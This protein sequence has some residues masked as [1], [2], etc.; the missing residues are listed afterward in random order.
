ML[1]SLQDMLRFEEREEIFFDTAESFSSEESFVVGEDLMCHNFGYNFLLNELKSVK[2]R[3]ENFLVRMGLMEGSSSNEVALNESETIEV[4]RV[5]EC[6]GA[7]TTTSTS[8]LE[9][10]LVCDSRESNGEANFIVEESGQEWSENLSTR[11]EGETTENSSSGV[12]LGSSNTQ[13]HVDNF[14]NVDVKKKKIRGWLRS[15]VRKMKKSRGIDASKAR[16]VFVEEG[17][18]TL[19][20]VQQRKKRCMEL[21]AVYAGQEIRAH[22]GIIWTMKFSPDG[23]YLASG[24][25]DGIVRIWSV[26]SVETSWTASGCNFKSNTE[27]NSNNNSKKLRHASVIIPDKIFQINDSPLHEFRGHTSDILD[28]AWSTSNVSNLAIS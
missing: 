26:S 6:S 9:E 15:L 13:T 2:E 8:S 16:K 19:M 10:N 21:T 12:E 22:K 3:R 20:K 27:G 4:D 14:E 7:V 23:Q 17:K 25:E 18:I 5:V 28:L 1:N 11:T 24:G